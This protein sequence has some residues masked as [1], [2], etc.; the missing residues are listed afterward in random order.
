M[1]TTR[2]ATPRIT[3]QMEDGSEHTIQALNVDLV[4]WERYRAKAQLPQPTDAPFLWM[5]FLAWHHLTKTARLLPEMKLA[6]FE[7]AAAYVASAADE[8]EEEEPGA[9]PT[10]LGPEAE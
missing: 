7:R 9:D 8:T 4:A 6:D 3:V 10:S 1:G 2:L 5:N